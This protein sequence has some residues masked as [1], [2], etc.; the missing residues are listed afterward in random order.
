MRVY[1]EMRDEMLTVGMPV[2]FEELYR[3]GYRRVY[4][5]VWALAGQSA[6][7]ELTQDAF[8]RAHR[9]WA[10]VAE[11][12]DPLQWVSRDHRHPRSPD[13]RSDRLVEQLRRNAALIARATPRTVPSRRSI[14]ERERGPGDA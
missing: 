2:R 1:G 5:L 12:D 9:N 10:E 14:P 4:R 3:T 13:A 11:L 6:A 8:L 7:E